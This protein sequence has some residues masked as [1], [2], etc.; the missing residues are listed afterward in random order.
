[1]KKALSLVIIL[2][3]AVLTFSSVAAFAGDVDYNGLYVVFGDSIAAGYG[4]YN[5]DM[6]Y[7]ADRDS[8]A[9]AGIVARAVDYDLENYAKSGA[10]STDLIAVLGRDEVQASVSDAELITVSIGGNDIFDF[11][12]LLDNIIIKQALLSKLPG[13]SKTNPQ[14]EALYTNLETNL[15][16]IMRTLVETNNGK[17]V[18]MLQTLYNPF[19]S[20]VLSSG[21]NLGQLIEYYIDRINE[22]YVKVHAEVGGFVLVDTAAAMNDDPDCFY[23][24]EHLDIH[25]TEH[26]HEVIAQTI[27]TLF[28]TILN[29]PNWTDETT[30]VEETTAETVPTRID[31]TTHEDYTEQTTPADTVLSTTP[32][33]T[34]LSTTADTE[35]AISQYETTAIS[36]E[37]QTTP[38]ETIATTSTAATTSTKSTTSAKSDDDVGGLKEMIGCSSTMGGGIAVIAAVCALACG[39]TFKKSKK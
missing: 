26:G 39:V 11:D 6:S 28:D 2:A 37:E 14:I 8:I 19:Y 12:N 17:G 18:I 23:D 29:D 21:T 24:M 5:T 10:T 38:I 25:P 3:F 7:V 15:T 9:Y 20:I 34:V 1:M 4:L 36:T 30:K 22:I 32:A 13:Q 27:L 31:M 33:D 16:Q 35:P